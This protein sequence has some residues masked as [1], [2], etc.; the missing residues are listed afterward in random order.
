M[1]IDIVREDFAIS[2]SPRA[3]PSLLLID[4]DAELCGLMRQFFES[5]GCRIETVQ[6]GVI[7]LSR[8]LEGGYDL[9]LLDVMLPGLNGFDLLRQLRQRSG[10]PVILLTA[11]TEKADRITGLDAGADDYLPKPFGPDE[12]MA[13]IRAVLRR[14][15]RAAPPKA[16]VLNENSVRLNPATREVWRDGAPV[17]V[18]SI[19][20]DILELLVRSAGRVV[21]R[22][23][24][25]TSLYRRQATPFERSLDVHVSH[26]RKKLAGG[27]ELIRTVRGVGYLFRPESE[28]EA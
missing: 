4:D 10:V 15:G 26:L 27:H 16:V 22:D 19:E 3:A 20:F 5:N 6:D 25:T 23:E 28:S 11:R 21:S 17:E 18:T 8:A 13:R 7:G 24:L 12:L 14:T 9:L 1:R 2:D